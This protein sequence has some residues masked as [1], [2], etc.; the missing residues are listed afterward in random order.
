MTRIET[1]TRTYQLQVLGRTLEHLGTQMYKRRDAAIAELVA[2]CWDAGATEVC[3]EIPFEHY[4]SSDSVILIK[5]NGSGMSADNIQED[6]LV[7]GRNKRQEEAR[8][9]IDGRLITGRKGI[10]K[11][12]GFGIASKMTLLTWQRDR[13]VEFTLDITELK[14]KDGMSESKP[15]VGT[16]AGHPEN[17]ESSNGTIVTLSGLKQTTPINIEQF[18]QSLFRRFSKRVRGEMKIFVNGE[19]LKEAQLNLVER[20]PSR[21]GFKEAT[22]S[23]G[24]KIKY[25][26]GIS[27]KIIKPV[28]MQGFSIMVREKIGQFSPFYFGV[29]GTASH[30]HNTK[31]FTGEV[32]ADYLDEGAGDEDDKVST[33]RQEISWSEP[34][35][36]A[37]NEWGQRATRDILNRIHERK[38][39]E[40]ERMVLEE[41]ES[42]KGRVQEL[43]QASRKS[44][45]RV[46]RTLGD[47]GIDDREGA[48]QI[49]DGLVRA[50]EFQQFFDITEEVEKIS[51]EDPIKLK[52]LLEQISNWK[53]LEGR[54]LLEIMHGRLKIID[55][56]HDFVVNDIP[57][58]ASSKS[59]D[60]LH[61]LI[62]GMPWLLDSEWQ[63]Y[64]E[65]KS[66]SS[67]LRDWNVV[68][69]KK[70]GVN[71]KDARLRYD[72]IALNGEH[73]LLV[74]E[75]KRSGHPVELEEMQRLERYMENLSRARENTV[76]GVL[77]CS[78]KFNVS[79]DRLDGYKQRSDYD[80]LDWSEIYEKNRRHYEHFKGI[81]LG[82]TKHK[83]FDKKVREAKQ[84]QVINNRGTIRR[85]KEER[86]DGLG[87]KQ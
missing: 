40:I 48:L 34:E 55:Y 16:L 63:L 66:I 29:E 1:Q 11:L 72:F 71:K 67:Q 36:G 45:K 74:I 20:F 76:K 70:I 80:I 65:E 64:Q 61:D 6:Y 38:A 57:E 2:N 13:S 59:D 54:A 68:D 33:D 18:H 52:D 83:D 60:N 69:L 31:Y 75:I 79:Q 14:A 37:L 22:L 82:D 10:G 5:D 81:V 53:V 23:D 9:R 85:T 51:K 42:L 26:Y 32:F 46:L 77:I 44:L 3:I 78:G 25:W 84:Y 27:E 17:I 19:P 49:A 41:D 39:D 12:A 24:N 86:K 8:D 21:H 47:S 62:A 7:I 87:P 4:N 58:V 73:E 56:L 30:Q 35:V 50:Y 15:I 28:M 43:D